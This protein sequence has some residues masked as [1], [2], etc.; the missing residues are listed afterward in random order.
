[1]IDSGGGDNGTWQIMHD[2]WINSIRFI[3]GPQSDGGPTI[4]LSRIHNLG[5]ERAVQLLKANRYACHFL[6]DSPYF[7]PCLITKSPSGRCKASFRKS[8]KYNEHDG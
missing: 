7:C 4:Q 3:C 6:T 1:M 2:L 5:A 8:K